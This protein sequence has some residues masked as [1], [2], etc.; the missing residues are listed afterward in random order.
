M[1]NPRGLRLRKID[2]HTHTPASACYR[3]EH[4]PEEIVQAALAY[5]MDAIAVTDH[6]TAASIDAMKAAAQAIEVKGRQLVIFPGVEISVHEGYHIIALFDPEVGQA[7]VENFLG[8]IGITPTEYGK[9]D[10]LCEK[11][12]FDVL[13]IIHK[14]G[15]L[16]VLAHIDEHKGAFYELASMDLET[17]KVRVPLS[18]ARLFDQGAYDAVEVTRGQLPAGFD[19]AHRIGRVPAFYQASDNPDP[20]DPI[21]HSK[22]G[23]G[24][25]YSCFNLDEITLEGLRQCFAD[26]EVRIILGELPDDE[27]WPHIVQMRIGNEGF[28]AYQ[29]FYFH[30]GLNCLIGGKGVG[31]SLV[32]EFLRFALGQ[33]SR[34]KDI[35]RDHRS[36]LDKQLQPFNEAEIEFALANG[37]TYILKRTYEGNGESSFTCTNQATGERYTGDIAQLFPLLAYSQTEV[38]KISEDENAQLH[39]LDSLFDARPYQKAIAEIQERLDDNDQALAEALDAQSR[40]EAAQEEIATLDEKIDNLDRLLDHPLVQQMRQAEAKRDAL[41]LQIR[42]VA[43]LAALRERYREEAEALSPP[44]L[45]DELDGD[46]VL[47]AQQARA[48]TVQQAILDALDQLERCLVTAQAA[49]SQTK[50]KWLPTFQSLREQYIAEL[51]GSDRAQLEAQRGRLVQERKETQD[52][53]KRYRALAQEALPKLMAERETWLGELDEH[54]RAYYEAR[55][56]KFDQLTAVS[57]GKLRLTLAHAANRATYEEAL[58]DLLAGSHIGVVS[59][60]N[61]RKIATHVLPRELGDFI[62]ARDVAGLCES[63]ELTETMARRAMDKL[64]AADNFAA[65]LALQHAYYPQD[66]PSIEFNKGRDKGRDQFAPLDELS[67]GQ[68]STA[69]LIIA[70]CDGQMPVIIDQPEDALD[71]ASVWEDIAKKLRRGKYGRQFILTTHNSSLAVGSD[72]DSFMVLTPQ[73]SDRAKVSYRGAIDR[74]DVRRAVIDHLEGGDEPYK[75]RQEKYNIK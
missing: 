73:S 13:E 3:H 21:H 36:K 67:V 4:S 30:R 31:K 75:L 64:W 42:Y 74:T 18:C 58:I 6:N 46:E 52:R 43:Q 63:S 7:D 56:R 61:R 25:R 38:V 57:E 33:P 9:S 10:A 37:V 39:L 66:A 29:R 51:Q 71:I 59:T 26:P 8:A 12:V 44:S 47:A 45:P 15:G 35:Q 50:V 54:H 48:A 32:I 14:R 19:A 23:I 53:L 22:D 27:R 24:T 72:S 28:L 60:A 20:A 11:G 1:A 16:A 17:G 55:K 41:D 68:K 34:N 49:I 5:G 69:L 40:V 65:V 2:L 62:I 70:L